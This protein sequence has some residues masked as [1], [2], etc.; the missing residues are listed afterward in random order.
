MI[1]ALANEQAP[2][3]AY[4]VVAAFL[5]FFAGITLATVLETLFNAPSTVEWIYIIIC[6]LGA[7]VCICPGRGSLRCPGK[8]LGGN[9]S[10]IQTPRTSNA[11]ASNKKRVVGCWIRGKWVRSIFGSPA[12]RRFSTSRVRGYIFNFLFGCYSY[13]RDILFQRGSRRLE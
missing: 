11:T 10:R 9:P 4:E 8:D 6:G 3:G 2:D 5:Y 12:T 7:H 1:N 13:A